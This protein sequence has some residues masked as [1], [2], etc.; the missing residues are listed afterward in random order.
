MV[1]TALY[2]ATGTPRRAD[3]HRVPEHSIR[4]LVAAVCCS[5]VRAILHARQPMLLWWGEELVQFYNDAFLPSFGQG[6]HPTALGQRARDCWPEVWPVVGAQI[7]DVLA[8]GNASWY[9]DV[10]V[11]IFRNGRIDDA[12]WIYNYS[13]VFDDDGAR[14]G[15]LIICTETTRG[16]VARAQLESA[17]GNAQ[18]ARRVAE[19]LGQEV[20]DQMRQAQAALIA[21]REAKDAAERRCSELE[22]KAAEKK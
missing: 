7:E 8:N 3:S 17:L 2:V 13:P 20:S 5:V 12:W 1:S 9:E 6:K 10:L 16:V 11:P 15:V 18:E 22:K 21:M 19:V 4:Y 14:V